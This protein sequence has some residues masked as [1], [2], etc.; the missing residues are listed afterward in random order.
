M[1]LVLDEG[2]SELEESFENLVQTLRDGFLRDLTSVAGD[3][4]RKT[5]RRVFQHPF[6][7]VVVIGDDLQG[8]LDEVPRFTHELEGHPFLEVR[9]W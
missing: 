3:P 7:V 9:H 4:Q 6:K 5:F 2:V 8:F 1:A